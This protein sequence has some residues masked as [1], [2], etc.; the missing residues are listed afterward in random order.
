M[1]LRL[2]PE[3]S[4]EG[5]EARTWIGDDDIKQGRLFSDALEDVFER[6]KRRP[7]GYSRFEGDYRKIRVG[8][9]R[10]WVIFR[11][12][13]DEIQVMAVMHQNRRPGYWKNR[14]SSWLG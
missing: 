6:I 2:H 8:K 9:F 13:G 10:Y 1:R 7:L 5:I 11:V 4:L 3:A 14:L 12:R